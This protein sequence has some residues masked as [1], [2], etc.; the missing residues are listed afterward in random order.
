[1]LHKVVRLVG[2]V[3]IV[4]TSLMMLEHDA[5]ATQGTG[6]YDCFSGNVIVRVTMPLDTLPPNFDQAVYYLDELQPGAT[7]MPLGQMTRAEGSDAHFSVPDGTTRV[8]GVYT[9]PNG[10]AAANWAEIT[11]TGEK[12]DCAAVTT[13][14][15]PSTTTTTI[16]SATTST[17]PPEPAAVSAVSPECIADAPFVM[18]TFGPQT[19]YVGKTAHITFFDVHGVAL[20]AHDAPYV[21]NGTVKLIYPGASVDAAGNATDWPGWKLAPNGNW[22]EDPSDAYLRDGLTVRIEVNPTAEAKV[23][24]PPATSTCANPNNTPSTTTSTSSTPPLAVTLPNTGTNVPS[25]LSVI[26]CSLLAVGVLLAI[27]AVRRPLRS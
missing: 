8:W 13:T 26:G 2:V 1:M 23:S 11:I 17:V 27:A 4:A 16:S 21:P 3:T 25:P 5:S 9:G 10:S 24:Y 22:V 15:A 19:R 14:T 7:G 18:V 12:P 20:E 6:T